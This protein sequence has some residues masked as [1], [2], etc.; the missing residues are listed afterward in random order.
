MGK[1]C[2]EN[3]DE[4]P[5]SGSENALI[6]RLVCN[7]Q[8]FRFRG[9]LVAPNDSA[10]G[11]SCFCLEGTLFRC[12]FTETKSI[13][14]FGCGTGA[15]LL[16]LSRIPPNVRLIGP[17]W[18]ASSIELVDCVRRSHGLPVESVL[19]DIFSPESAVAENCSDADATFTLHH[20]GDGTI[21][22]TLLALP[23]LPSRF[24]HQESGSF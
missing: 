22:G 18:A 21:G 10:S 24:R 15:N 3:L 8:P 19:F 7:N 13:V 12:W 17:D 14:E 9:D 6:P 4:F 1:G 11:D 16:H 20:R 23:D 2:T 5:T